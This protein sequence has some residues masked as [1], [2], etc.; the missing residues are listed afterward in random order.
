MALPILDRL[1]DKTVKDE[2]T[3]CWLWIGS[4]DGRKGYGKIRF[5]YRKFAVHRV[6]AHLFLGLDITNREEQA[7]HKPICPNK[8]C[9][10]PDHLYV[11]TRYDN[12]A[13]ATSLGRYTATRANSFK[14]QCPAGH[15]LDGE[16]GDGARYCKTC[17][18]MRKQLLS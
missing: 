16:R 2:K 6:S 18:K 9:W 1:N 12:A 17:D 7:L 11:G 8:N 3:G 5:K 4:N 13:D 14:T 10:N 15:P